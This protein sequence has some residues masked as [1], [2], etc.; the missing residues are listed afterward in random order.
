MIR[1]VLVLLG[2]Q[3]FQKRV[4][5]VTLEVSADLVHF[6][7][8][9]YGVV[10]SA[11]LDVGDDSAGDGS[12]VS[13][14]VASD[15]SLVSHSAQG[16][17]GE[18]T[19]RSACDGLGDGGLTYSRR[20]HQTDDGAFDGLIQVDDRQIFKDPLLDLFHAVMILVKDLFGL[21]QVGVDLG[22]FLPRQAYDGLH[23]ISDD[24]SVCGIGAHLGEL[25]D[26]AF[27]LLLVLIF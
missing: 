21:L 5:R 1:E 9:E 13:P 11:V 15:L 17:S 14:S 25:G 19:S 2:I 20:A 6:I 18:F 7:E 27:N 4:R 23:I 10:N 8:E 24:G 26:L 3:H 16:H 12:D 22:G